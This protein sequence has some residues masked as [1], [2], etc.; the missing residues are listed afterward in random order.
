MEVSLAVE[1][2]GEGEGEGG[3]ESASESEKFGIGPKS[4]FCSFV[5]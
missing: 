2:G 4:A 3:G 1:R 5:K